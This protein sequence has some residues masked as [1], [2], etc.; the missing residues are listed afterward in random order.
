M[1]KWFS[2]IKLLGQANVD[3]L[4]QKYIAR[5]IKALRAALYHP[6]ILYTVKIRHFCFIALTNFARSLC[7]NGESQSQSNAKWCWYIGLTYYF[8]WFWCIYVEDSCSPLIFKIFIFLRVRAFHT[9][10]C[11]FFNILWYFSQLP[12]VQKYLMFILKQNFLG[13]PFLKLLNH[14]SHY[15]KL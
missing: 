7:Q 5:G 12:F 4:L 2:N 13:N 10:I 8:D 9:Q 3:S 15:K 11:L 1:F 6:Q 14:Q